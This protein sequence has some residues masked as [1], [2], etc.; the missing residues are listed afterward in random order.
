MG[1]VRFV[2]CDMSRAF[3]RVPHHLLLSHISK[4]DLPNLS[5]FVNWLNSYL[6]DRQQRVK[7]GVVKSSLTAV[8]SGVPQ[9]SV[10]GS[11]FYFYVELQTLPQ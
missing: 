9:G 11:F 3:D 6:S 10:L 8:T 2:T 5:T 4:L 7:L 1:A